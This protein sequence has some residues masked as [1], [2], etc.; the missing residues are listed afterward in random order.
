[1]IAIALLISNILTSQE[2]GISAWLSGLIGP[3]FPDGG[4]VFLLALAVLTTVL[5]NLCNNIAICFIMIN[6]VSSM[7]MNGFDVNLLAAVIIISLTTTICAFLTPAS[8]MPGAMLHADSNLTAA[9]V[10]KG[11]VILMLYSIILLMVIL[12]P[13][14]MLA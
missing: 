3:L 2:T 13:Y 12:V 9:A 1:M 4:F 10:Y 11:T 8:S 14:V 6:I 7:Y 5:T